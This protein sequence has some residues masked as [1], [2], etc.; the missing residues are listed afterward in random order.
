MMKTPA[1]PMVDF[2]EKALRQVVAALPSTTP[3][4][5]MKLLPPVLR[6]W[7]REDLREHLSRERRADVRERENR[8]QAIKTKTE[9]LLTAYFALDELGTS[10]VALRAQIQRDSVDAWVDLEIANDRRNNAIFWLNDLVEALKEPQPIPKPDTATKHYLVMRDMAAIFELITGD[11]AT[12]RTDIDAGTPYGPFWDFAKA[13]WSAIYGHERGLQNAVKIWA[14]GE[15]TQR[16][17]ANTELGRAEE[18]L[19]RRLDK[20]IVERIVSRCRSSSPFVVNLQYKHRGLWRK[21]KPAT[22]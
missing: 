10:E 5:R 22:R 14:Q 9:D 8:F 3:L 11:A 19:G 15:S 21:F 16:K 12:R 2:S 20:L 7:A 18:V 4:E 1:V 17:L 13:L 6:A